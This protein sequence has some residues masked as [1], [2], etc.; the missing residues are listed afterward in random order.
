MIR[1]C[2]LK[3]KFGVLKILLCIWFVYAHVAFAAVVPLHT[4][5]DN[6]LARNNNDEMD[7]S[8]KKKKKKSK[9][10]KKRKSSRK[11]SASELPSI[12]DLM[13]SKHSAL[14]TKQSQQEEELSKLEALVEMGY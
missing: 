8:S 2:H 7:D 6:L 12:Q 13:E 4:K 14:I 5:S 3:Y 9:K 1:T 10:K 11:Q